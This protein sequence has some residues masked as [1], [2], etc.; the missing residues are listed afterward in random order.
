MSVRYYHGLCQRYH[1]RPV[2]VRTH[3][4]RV[5]RGIIESVDQRCV[6]LRSLDMPGADLGGF[7]YGGGFGFGPGFGGYGGYG[8]GYRVALGAI[9]ALALLPLIFW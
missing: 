4:G 9:A 7:G 5:Y 3:N 8:R 6:Y 2:E 1:G